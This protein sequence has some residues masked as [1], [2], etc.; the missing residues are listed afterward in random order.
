M[1]A[2]LI[3]VQGIG[4]QKNAPT[5]LDRRQPADGSAWQAPATPTSLS[6]PLCFDVTRPMPG[7]ELDLFVKAH[8]SRGQAKLE[9]LGQRKG[10][11]MG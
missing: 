5:L 3:P 6:K 1:A 11:E 8:G 7:E 9:G 4:P 10:L 2:A